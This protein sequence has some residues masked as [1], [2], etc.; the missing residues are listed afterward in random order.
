MDH[1]VT[2]RQTTLV[3]CTSIA[4]QPLARGTLDPAP[5]DAI[6]DQ[7]GRLGVLAGGL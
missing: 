4:S 6:N 1:D 7:E 2:S 3:D 5:A